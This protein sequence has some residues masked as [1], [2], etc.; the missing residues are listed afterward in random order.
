MS[1]WVK[2]SHIVLV[3][4]S[5]RSGSCSLFRS[6]FNLGHKSIAEMYSEPYRTSKT[7]NFAKIA[8]LLTISAKH[9]ILDVWQVGMCLCKGQIGFRLASKYQF[10][11]GK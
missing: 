6:T 3:K 7:E 4:M 2:I 10:K 8:E 1:F 9:S 11:V 5:Y